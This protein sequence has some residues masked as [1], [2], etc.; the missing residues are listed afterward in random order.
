MLNMQLTCVGEDAGVPAAKYHFSPAVIVLFDEKFVV[1]T[2]VV[3]GT[4][5]T[6]VVV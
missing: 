6:W 5:V 3:T 4:K 1:A 2:V